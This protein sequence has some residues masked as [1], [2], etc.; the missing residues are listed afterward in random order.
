MRQA[1]A[2]E[3]AGELDALLASAS[4]AT[5]SPVP[6]WAPPSATAGVSAGRRRCRRPQ[7]ERVL[8]RLRPEDTLVV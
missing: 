4:N 3:L 5:G 1:R 7:L 2:S 8:E 6:R